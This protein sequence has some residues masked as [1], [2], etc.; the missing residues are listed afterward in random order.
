M[1][2]SQGCGLSCCMFHGLLKR[3]CILLLLVGVFY[4]C[5]KSYWCC[6]CFEFYYILVDFLSGCSINC[7]ERSGEVSNCNCGVVFVCVSIPVMSLLASHI[8]GL[9]RLLQT[10]V[11]LLHLLGR[12][13]LLLL[14]A[15][16]LSLWQFSWLWSLLYL[17]LI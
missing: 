8:L 11:G 15:V 5:L 10:Y 3:M 1:F 9:C 2:Y 6:W 12:A 4:K 7:W 13:S 14:Y 17:L 16:L